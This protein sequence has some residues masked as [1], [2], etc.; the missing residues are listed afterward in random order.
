MSRLH[1]RNGRVYLAATNGGNAAPVVSLSSWSIDFSVDQADATAFGDTNKQYVAGLPDASGAFS[2]F[3]DDAGQSLVAAAR[4]GLSRKMYLY[5][6]T[7]DNTKYWYGSVLVDASF[8]GAVDKAIS[9]SAKW[10]AAGDI[11]PIGIT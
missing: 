7:S 9:A 6:S 1:G 10:K 4:D 2:G 11:T 3:Y 8:E 5:P